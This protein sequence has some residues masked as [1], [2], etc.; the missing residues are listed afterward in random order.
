MIRGSTRPTRIMILNYY[1]ASP[2]SELGT[3][4]TVDFYD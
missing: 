1:A 2:G 3:I 4:I